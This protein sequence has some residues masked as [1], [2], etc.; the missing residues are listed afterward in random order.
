MAYAGLA[1]LSGSVEEPWPDVGEWDARGG[2]APGEVVP[3][4]QCR[5][6]QQ[7]PALGHSPSGRRDRPALP[8][9]S[10]LARARTR[11][12]RGRSSVPLSVARRRRLIGCVPTAAPRRRRRVAEEVAAMPAMPNEE[13][14][15]MIA[16]DT[17]IGYCPRPQ[18]PTHD[19]INQLC[20]FMRLHGCRRAGMEA[21]TAMGAPRHSSHTHAPRRAR[22]LTT[23]RTR[24]RGG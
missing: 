6:C 14:H 19:A 21:T 1:G 10:I 13:Q 23:A 8:A 9:P 24:P 20:S 2:S 16:G 18:T 22:T 5:E 4:L 3:D 7:P 15:A 17:N 12:R 11:G